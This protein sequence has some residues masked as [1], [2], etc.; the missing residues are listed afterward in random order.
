[1]N[2]AA[3]D[4]TSEHEQALVRDALARAQAIVGA[5][6]AKARPDLADIAALEELI[7][8]S[9]RG[10]Q[11]AHYS[12]AQMEAALGP[13]F[14]VDRQLIRDG[15]FYVVET[16]GAILGCGGWSRRRSLFGG[17][18]DR[19]EPDPE[20]DP[21]REPARIRAFFVHPQFTFMPR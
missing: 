2:D 17:D 4:A 13:I 9:V 10:L 21:A 3:V 20:L 15:T 16:S 5:A 1:M 14:G 18:K 7:P 8:A 11:T 12:P 19:T 6:E